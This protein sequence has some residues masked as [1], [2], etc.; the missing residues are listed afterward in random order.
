MPISLKKKGG[1]SKEKK[2]VTAVK[3]R[4]GSF[5]AGDATAAAAAS[6]T[7]P[8]N[9]SILQI[10]C[11]KANKQQFPVPKEELD[12][13]NKKI[14]NEKNKTV[15]HINAMDDC[16]ESQSISKDYDLPNFDCIVTLVINQLQMDYKDN[17]RDSRHSII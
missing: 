9:G 15:K 4:N 16:Q 14:P 17:I 1:H 10:K 7:W 3:S 11:K 2:L 13:L 5:A 6:D 12:G 8:E